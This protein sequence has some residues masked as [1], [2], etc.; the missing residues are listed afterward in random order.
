MIL[1]VNFLYKKPITS[2]LLILLVGVMAYANSFQVP[3]VLDDKMSITLNPVIKSL[4]NFF[5][6]SI[7]YHFLPNRVVGYLTF[8]LNYRFGGLNLVGYHAVNLFIHLASGLL[9]YSLVR[10]TLKT[11][12][13]R[14]QDLD[15]K[16]SALDPRVFIPL[17][18]ALLF[19]AHPIQTQAVTYIVQRLASL[20]TLFYLLSVVLYAQ[21]RLALEARGPRSESRR[22]KALGLRGL[23]SG[24]HR[25]KPIFS[26]AGS[27][28]AAVLAMKTKEISFTLPLAILLYE[29]CFFRGEWKQRL[30]YLLPLLATLPIIPL[31]V[32][33]FGGPVGHILSDT[34]GQLRVETGVPRLDYLITQFRVIVSYLRLLVLPVNQNL[35]YDYPIFTTFFTPSV[36]F[37]FLLLVA[38]FALAV[39]LFWRTR[40]GKIY[41]VQEK[42]GSVEHQP[43]PLYLRLVSFGI[44]WFFLTLSVESSIVPIVDVIVEHRLYLPGIGAAVAFAAT[45]WLL[46]ERFS[47]RGRCKV[48]LLVATLLVIGLGFATYQRNQVWGNAIR[49]WKDTA[50]KSPHK[51]RP[52]NNLGVALEV[53]G[54]R[55]EAFRILS[56][57]VEIDPGYY[58]SYYNLADLYLVSD[59]PEKAIPLLR[60]AIRM[61][62]YFTEAYVDMGAALMRSGH[63]R[64]VVTYLERNLEH[65]RDNAEAH[66]Y[67]GSAY[68]FLG[69]RDAAMRQL[70]IVSRHDKALAA[71]L[72]GMLGVRSPHGQE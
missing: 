50:A 33:N 45:Y 16:T 53:A 10:L 40:D 51:G 1:K 20:A 54:N 44:F 14:N 15:S 25:L 9:V 58:K 69:N 66:F 59:Q 71:S 43:G 70:E 4:D 64:E 38:L 19:V 47:G 61:K 5:C 34:E 12:F 24:F 67:L 3:F 56:R 6:N 31:T 27:V 7:G 13:F 35:D 42:S 30:L 37:S 23:N 63:F 18:A 72:A 46:A 68:V 11:P 32:M 8:A 55:S 28:L 62:P 17:F 41:Q 48:F 26:L 22:S 21:A 52:L 60:T 29:L 65:V 36:F 2:T 49:L 57:A 39:Y